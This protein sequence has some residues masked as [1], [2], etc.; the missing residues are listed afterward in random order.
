MKNRGSQG[1]SMVEVLITIVITSIGL[2]G[3]G[4]LQLTSMK[5]INNTQ[6]RSLATLYAYDMAERMRSNQAGVQSGAYDNITGTETAVSCVSVCI[7]SVVAQ[8]DAYEWNQLI[9][10]GVNGSVDQGSLP[11][12]NGTVSNNGG[13][14]TITI[15]WDEQD[16]NAAVAGISNESFALTVEI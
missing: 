2:L 10:T 8:K 13:V 15:T 3:L 6:F 11:S 4:A 12:G 1:F 5:N 16:Q 9:K 14:F 7:P